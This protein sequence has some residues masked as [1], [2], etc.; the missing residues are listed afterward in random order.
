MG[1]QMR[2]ALLFS[3]SVMAYSVPFSHLRKP[4]ANAKWAFSRM[5]NSDPIS[6]SRNQLANAK[7]ALTRTRTL[8]VFSLLLGSICSNLNSKPSIV[9]HKSYYTHSKHHQTINYFQF[10]NSP[11][12]SKNPNNGSHKYNTQYILLIH[13]LDSN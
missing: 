7:W 4:V 9:Q 11:K 6:H 1:S 2:N 8:L 10:T 3:V 13:H 5:P 12:S